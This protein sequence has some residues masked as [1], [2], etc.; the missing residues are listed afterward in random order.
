MPKMYQN[1][2]RYPCAEQQLDFGIGVSSP[3]PVLNWR[4]ILQCLSRREWRSEAYEQ[5]TQ[6]VAVSPSPRV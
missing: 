3:S 6:K 4:N 1:L 5:D 2:Y